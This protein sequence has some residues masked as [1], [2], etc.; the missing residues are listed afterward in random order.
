MSDEIENEVI[1][2]AEPEEIQSVDPA[3][4]Q[5]RAKG[6]VSLEEWQ[7]K[8]NDV[9]DWVGYNRFNEKGDMIS[10]INSLKNDIKSVDKRLANNNEYWKAQLETQKS[11][12]L[13][14]R[15]EAITQGDVD[16]VNKLDGEINSV[17]QQ[18]NSLAMPEVSQEDMKAELAFYDSL[19][20]G[21]QAFAQQVAAPLIVN[22]LSGQDLVNAVSA[23]LEREF[24][25]TN[26]KRNNASVTDGKRTTSTKKDDDSVSLDTLSATDKAFINTMKNTGHFKG[27]SDSEILKTI[28]DSKR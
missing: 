28:Q 5:A 11:E 15:N 3:E 7:E 4:A 6:W 8:G 9:N 27:M 20:K 13:T 21:K 14:K 1:A 24:P 22:G 2:D 12:L 10:S 18:V 16:A 26:P 19:P 25:A 23:E 17:D